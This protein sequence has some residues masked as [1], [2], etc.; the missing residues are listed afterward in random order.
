MDPFTKLCQERYASVLKS[1]D[2]CM[3]QKYY[4]FA[5]HFAFVLARLSNFI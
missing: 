3:D 2:H 1:F 5:K 4:S